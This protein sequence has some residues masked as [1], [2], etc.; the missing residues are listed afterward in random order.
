MC[1]RAFRVCVWPA[2]VSV[3][4]GLIRDHPQ[5][6]QRRR[7]R[8]AYGRSSD[9]C[10]PS[11]GALH[12]ASC[13]STS[14]HRSG[15]RMVLSA[16]ALLERR[17]GNST[18]PAGSEQR[19]QAALCRERLQRRQRSEG[20]QSGSVPAPISL[21]KATSGSEWR[22][23]KWHQRSGRQ[24]GDKAE[25]PATRVSEF[26]ATAATSGAAARQSFAAAGGACERWVTRPV[27]AAS[28][29]SCGGCGCCERRR[30]IVVR[31][32]RQ[33]RLH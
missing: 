28:G 27:R 32:R 14:S 1:L 31:L 3:C 20:A 17:H 9:K 25:R 8:R 16:S 15:E 23:L 22:L 21:A 26:G 18:A 30:E 13:E 5:R 7:R 29:S 10:A 33:V 4:G 19:W 12:R 2:A 6:Q 11:G 24:S